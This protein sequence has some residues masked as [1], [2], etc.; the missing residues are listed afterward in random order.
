MSD[1]AVLVPA[2]ERSKHG[3]ERGGEQTSG[4]GGEGEGEGEGE[5]RESQRRPE[6]K[7]KQRSSPPHPSAE[8]EERK[9]ERSDSLGVVSVDPAGN[10]VVFVIRV[11]VDAVEAGAD[12][13]S[14]VEGEARRGGEGDRS[15][16]G[17][18]AGE[19]GEEK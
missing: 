14:R 11:A 5:E 12:W 9:R 13:V 7:R 3:W 17:A 1:I 15:D 19:E 16:R 2:S 10:A 4:Q 6:P 18:E 8:P